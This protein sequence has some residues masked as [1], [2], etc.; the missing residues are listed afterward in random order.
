M[1]RLAL[2]FMFKL[3]TMCMFRTSWCNKVILLDA[4]IWALCDDA[5]LCNRCVREFL[6]LGIYMVRIRFTFQN[7]VWHEPRRK[8]GDKDL[9]IAREQVGMKNNHKG[10]QINGV[11]AYAHSFSLFL[12][13][14]FF[15]LW[16]LFHLPFYILVFH[17]SA[18][19]TRYNTRVSKNILICLS[20]FFLISTNRL[21]N[22]ETSN[23]KTHNTKLVG[24]FLFLLDIWI[25][26][27]GWRKW[28]ILTL[29]YRLVQNFRITNIFTSKAYNSLII[30]LYGKLK[31]A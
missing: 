22:L 2:R 12:I 21:T 14:F 3:M 27:F 11:P 30:T 10:T 25:K 31:V 4:I 13:F 28:E 9:G 5:Q 26:Y 17:K 15:V 1:F 29:K 16:D 8:G 7:R 20:H 6:I 19:K 18:T 23:A 24:L